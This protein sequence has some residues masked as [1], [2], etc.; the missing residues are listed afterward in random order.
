MPG[1]SFGSLF[2]I[3]TFGESHGRLVGV[4]VDGVPAGLP[5]SESD[6]NA[7]LALRRPGLHYV[8]PRKER[9]IAR[10]VSGVFSGRTTGAP[11]AIVVENTDVD[12]SYYEK[13]RYTPRPGHADLPYIFRYGFENWDYRGGGRASARETVA[14]VAAGAIAKKLLMLLGTMV[15][16]C[17]ESMGAVGG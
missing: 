17:V 16:G 2:R 11:V 5:L 13:I 3:T 7:E 10:I 4:V 15:A 8:S 1:N 12:S 9:D 6:I 14:R